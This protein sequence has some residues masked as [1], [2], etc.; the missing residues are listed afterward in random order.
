M[1][2]IRL[3]KNDMAR[4]IVQALLNLPTL[5]DANHRRVT[6]MARASVAVLKDRHRLA[7]KILNDKVAQAAWPNA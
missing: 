3:T 1:T 6:K 7:V 5:P 4:V 2:T